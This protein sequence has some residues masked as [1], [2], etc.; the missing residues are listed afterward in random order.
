MSVR[1][2]EPSRDNIASSLYYHHVQLSGEQV[3]G[4]FMV[5]F[6]GGAQFSVTMKIDMNGTI[7]LRC[8]PPTANG[9]R[10]DMKKSIAGNSVSVNMDSN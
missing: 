8:D 7:T 10:M 6:L 4:S 9:V 1:K 3:D 5:K 2:C